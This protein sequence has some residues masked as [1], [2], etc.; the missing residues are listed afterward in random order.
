MTGLRR[1]RAKKFFGFFGMSRTHAGASFWWLAPTALFLLIAFIVP[2]VFLLKMAAGSSQGFWTELVQVWMRGHTRRALLNGVIL[3]AA[4]SVAAMLLCLPPA[5]LLARSRFRGRDAS[6]LLLSLPLAFSGVI[7][8]FLAIVMLGRVGVIP[9]V[10]QA[11]FG[12]PFGSGLAYALPG[13]FLAYLFF[14]IPRAV[15]SLEAAFIKLDPELDA[16]ARTLGA[17]RWQRWRRVKLPALWPALAGTFA[18]TFAVS[19]GSFGAALILSRRF[20]VLPVEIYTEFTAFSNDAAACAMAIWL[21]AVSAL[22]S[23]GAARATAR[24]G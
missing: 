4:V 9:T 12:R 23:W 20:F 16:A 22:V 21:A 17:T 3:S 6:R 2:V 15:L 14:E 11:L 18:T 1:R 19:L 8:G 24:A 13:L 10:S 5:Q 7:V